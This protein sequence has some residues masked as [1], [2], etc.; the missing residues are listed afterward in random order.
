MP[1]TTPAAYAKQ[2]GDPDHFAHV[3]VHLFTP[4]LQAA[5]LEV[6]A[7]SATG[8]AIIHAEIIKN[9]EQADYVLC[10][11][12]DLNPNVLFELGIRTSLDRPVMHVRDN[13]TAKI[14]FDIA[15]VNTHT[16]DSSLT[17]WSL[18][19]EIPSLA[20]FIKH[21]IASENPGNSMWNYF[22]I[23]KRGKPFEVSGDPTQAKLDLIL[24]ELV[25]PPVVPSITERLALPGM[26]FEQ[27]DMLLDLVD[28]F[29]KQNGIDKYTVG[30]LRE[31]G[32][33]QIL[34]V[35]LPK[36][37]PPLPA[38]TLAVLE[39]SLVDRGFGGIKLMVGYSDAI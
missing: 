36:T 26:P 16:Y 18:A 4:A 15:A 1:I 2:L 22:G 6:R 33:S 27:T 35:I 30:D 32:N 20:E 37:M 24:R 23:T 25:K 10:D 7:P 31:H 17:P 34:P 8:S 5:G 13:L 19:N 3:L 12:S 28:S 21:V 38:K 14:P 39:R 9:L 11:L 29:M